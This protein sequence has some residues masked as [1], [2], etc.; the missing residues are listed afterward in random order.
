MTTC[1]SCSREVPLATAKHCPECG[2][3]LP[4][5]CA[6]CGCENPPDSKFCAEC[7][8]PIRQTRAAFSA[9]SA[10]ALN[11]AR[12]AEAPGALPYAAGSQS[13]DHIDHRANVAAPP[14]ATTRDGATEPAR[15]QA[16]M[17]KLTTASYVCAVIFPLAGFVL[18]IITLVR[19]RLGHGLA[20][21][22]LSLS[23]ALFWMAFV[24]GFIGAIDVQT[25]VACQASLAGMNCA[26]E[27]RSG[28]APAT[29]CWDVMLTCRNG[30]KA[31]ASG[32]HPVPPGV[33]S[34]STRTIGYSDIRRWDDCDEVETMAVDN[35]RLS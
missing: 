25:Y 12:E 24:Q 28:D 22:G 20:A 15:E 7:G 32:C 21:L 11:P 10:R 13:G 26:V 18:A 35:M 2:S 14:G 19:G 29:V 4:I 3:P 8:R 1:H 33:G 17:S 6:A 30:V 31:V 27:R 23:M 5:V 9:P 34:K 16:D